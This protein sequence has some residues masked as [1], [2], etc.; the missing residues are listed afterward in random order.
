M[1]DKVENVVTRYPIIFAHGIFM[2]KPLFRVF[3]H[4]RKKLAELG[5]HAYIADTD[6]V[7]TIENNAEQLKKQ[8][9]EILAREGAEKI[10]IIAHSKGGLDSIYMIKELGMEEKVASLTTICTPH[11]GS[12]V[13]T[14]VTKLPSWLLRFL[15]FFVNI[16]YRLLKDERPDV[17]TACGQLKSKEEVAS[18]GV[19]FEKVYCQ[20]YSSTMDKASSDFL[21][22]V[23]F[24]ISRH[25]EKDLSDGMVSNGSAS[26]FGEYKGECLNES[27][28][29]NEVVCFMTG[30][31]KKERVVAFYQTLCADLS[32]RGY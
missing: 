3:V 12:Q 8:I 5:Y 2:K 1:I 25:Y 29:H 16:F 23:P 31:K 24:L 27:I 17:V 20:S 14:W 22:S 18:E 30:R 4:I 21:L 15:G 10:N 13:A 7:G 19:C 26:Q 9:E 11:K 28:S 32:A 6:G